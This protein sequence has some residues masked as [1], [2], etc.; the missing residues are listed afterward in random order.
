MDVHRRIEKLEAAISQPT[1]REAWVESHMPEIERRMNAIWEVVIVDYDRFLELL[2]EGK[3]I[4]QPENSYGWRVD[5]MQGIA[6]K[7][8]NLIQYVSLAL[9]ATFSDEEPF[10]HTGAWPE[11]TESLIA[12]LQENREAVGGNLALIYFRKAENIGGG[13]E[14]LP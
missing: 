13:Q 8:G 10:Y 9:K 2:R 1:E 3:A 4:Y 7:D 5:W 6:P 12:F 11:N 14:A